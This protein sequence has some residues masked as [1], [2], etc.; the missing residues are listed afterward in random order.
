M[1]RREEWRK[2]V[3]TEREETEKDLTQRAQRSEHRGHGDI[4][5]RF[6]LRLADTGKRGLLGHRQ[7][8]LCYL[9]DA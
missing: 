2:E 5:A 7:E 9:R 3:M 1:R 4:W 6:G 8:C